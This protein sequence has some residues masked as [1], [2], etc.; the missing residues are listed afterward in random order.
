MKYQNKEVHELSLMKTILYPDVLNIIDL[1]LTDLKYIFIRGEMIHSCYLPIPIT[2]TI[3][4]DKYYEHAENLKNEQ[5]ENLKN[6]YLKKEIKE[7]KKQKAKGSKK[8]K[9]VKYNN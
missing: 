6:E 1:Q 7:I 5:V 9:K 3:I 4:K 2:L 8:Y